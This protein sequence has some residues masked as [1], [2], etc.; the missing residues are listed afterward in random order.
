M[1][2]STNNSVSISVSDEESNENRIRARTRRKRKKPGH[3]TTFE[4]PRYFLRIFLRYWIV[5]VFLLAVGLLL[6]ESTRIIT[7]SAKLKRS[8]DSIPNKKNEGNLNRL[9]PTTKVIG[10]VRQRK[11]SLSLS[12]S[13]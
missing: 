8:P 3:R 6:F 11:L 13:L 12:H 10:G 4:L 7:K 5:L 2:S 9:D 1:F